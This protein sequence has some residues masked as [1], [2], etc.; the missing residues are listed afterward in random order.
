MVARHEARACDAL[1]KQSDLN[2]P[3][4]RLLTHPQS[5][6]GTLTGVPNG[7]PL[8]P[9]AEGLLKSVLETLEDAKAEDVIAIDLE[10]KT[11]LADHMVIASGRSD[12]HVGAVA[13]QVCRMLK[14]DGFGRAS[15]EGLETGDWVLI[16]AGDV[17]IHVFRPEVRNF[18]NLEKMWSV[19]LPE[20]A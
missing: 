10:G 12:R 16:D 2:E 20:N 13:D 7:E 18:Y 14:N 6:E 8:P 11:S 19:E 15:V 1:A 9:S 3:R 4:N 17:V 5:I